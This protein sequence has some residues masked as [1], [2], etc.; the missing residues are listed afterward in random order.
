[1]FL[2]RHFCRKK[3][4]FSDPLLIFG[5]RSKVAIIM[6]D[7]LD[8]IMVKTVRNLESARGQ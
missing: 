6:V 7:F 2:I 5:L 3:I 8:K 4:F 1:M